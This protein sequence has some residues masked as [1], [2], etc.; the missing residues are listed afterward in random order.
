MAKLPHVTGRDLLSALR[1]SGFKLSHVR[2][3]HHYL[4][5]GAGH[6]VTVPVHAGETIPPGTLK[7]ILRT[8][9]LTVEEL[10]ELL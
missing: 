6:L 2:G 7:A 3:S 5:R 9:D 8:A 4:R 1:K 10:V